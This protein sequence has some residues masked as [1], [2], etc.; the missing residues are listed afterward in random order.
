MLIIRNSLIVVVMLLL[1]YVMSIGCMARWVVTPIVQE[2]SKYAFTEYDRRLAYYYMMFH[3][4]EW[5]S[6]R[7]QSYH[8]LMARI[9]Y[10]YESW[11]T[12]KPK[13]QLDHLK[14]SNFC[15]LPMVFG[16]SYS[17]DTGDAIDVLPFLKRQ[18]GEFTNGSYAFYLRRTGRLVVH[19]TQDN[20][21]FACRVGSD[22]CMPPYNAVEYYLP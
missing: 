16:L 5:L 14:T 1:L 3:P 22:Y 7:E 17:K 8:Y 4:I 11:W 9:L 19:G 13:R 6:V 12:P 10:Q 2:R 18:G 15:I 20:L 21:D